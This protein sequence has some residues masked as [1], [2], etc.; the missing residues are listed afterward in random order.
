MNGNGKLIPQGVCFLKVPAARNGVRIMPPG[1]NMLIVA[2]W[3]TRV[4][5]KDGC[6]TPYWSCG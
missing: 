3:A 1:F 4:G 6:P 5:V 2:V